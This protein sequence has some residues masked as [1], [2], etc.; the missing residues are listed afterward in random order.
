M[1]KQGRVADTIQFLRGAQVIPPTAQNL[2]MPVA[3]WL[4]EI[5]ISAQID[6]GMSQG[7][8]GSES[9]RKY[10][11]AMILI[12]CA[13]NRVPVAVAKQAVA[14]YTDQ[15][16]QAAL[17]TMLND[18]KRLCAPQRLN[19]RLQELLANPTQFLTN[20]RIKTGRG[21]MR[22]SGP[23]QYKFLWD[24]NG[25]FYSMEPVGGFQDDLHI[26]FPG[27][28]IA[29]TKFTDVKN[30]LGQIAGAAVTGN[31]GLTTQLSGCSIFYSVNAGNLVVAHVWPDSAAEVKAKLPTPLTGQ[32][33]LPAGAVLA[34]R[35]AHEGGLSN[36]I[37][38]G[39]LG[40]YGMVADQAHTGLRT[41][42]PSNMRM[43]GYV[44]TAGNA[45]FIA[46]RVGPTWQLFGQQNNPGRPD[47]GVSAIQRIYP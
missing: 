40:I 16:L 17:G 7:T 37:T 32:A 25:K 36:A 27:Y 12:L 41:I 20:N 23:G 35:L 2:C 44:D 13:L 15:Q 38:G 24:F 47:S 34:L 19:P 22:N 31:I 9:T 30:N 29:V 42:G 45:Y 46:V 14:R 4:E 8:K 3:D 33:G 21:A 1:P 39:T 5:N 10:R 11:R 26:T 28:N 43:H 6:Q 18:V